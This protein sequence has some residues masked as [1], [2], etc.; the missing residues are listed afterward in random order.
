MKAHR[1]PTPRT[2]LHS[3]HGAFHVPTET[4]PQSVLLARAEVVPAY[5]LLLAA[6]EY[7]RDA[8]VD[9]WQFAVETDELRERGA[10]SVDLRWLIATGLAEHRRE[11]TIPGDPER[12]FRNL[13]RT[14]LPRRTSIALTERG[15][16]RLAALMRE[17][18][19]KSRSLGS[20]GAATDGMPVGEEAKPLLA[21]APRPVWDQQ[22]RE[23]RFCEQV[24]KHFRV[25]APNQEI[26]LQAF[27]EENW[28]HCVDDPLPPQD[29][30]PI[31]SRLLAT[32]KSLNRSQVKPLI[33]FHGNGNGVQVY[34]ETRAPFR[35]Q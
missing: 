7:G 34:W 6:Y 18:L 12:S 33:L 31:K 16:A 21:E 1:P 22:R 28:P 20:S 26:I 32:I 19:E 17:K 2:N 9:P 11:T 14:G 25:P 27:Q 23:L 5:R 8:N 35:M 15:A 3:T 13:P 29:N 4:D 24:V 30:L 10:A